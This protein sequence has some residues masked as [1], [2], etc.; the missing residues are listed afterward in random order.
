GQQQ[1]LSLARALL[2]RPS[3]LLLDDPF[4]AVDVPTEQ[5]IMANL[6]SIGGDTTILIISHRL[7]TFQQADK[8]II[9]E[10]GRLA[11]Q[12]THAALLERREESYIRLCRRQLLQCK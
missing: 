2:P 7:Q 3:F 4:S 9:L 12:G 8:V 1:R 6:R 11:A 10:R 5:R